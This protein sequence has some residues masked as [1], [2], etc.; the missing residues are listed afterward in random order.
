MVSGDCCV[1]L[2]CDTIGLSAV[3]GCG[4]C[5]SYSLTTHIFAS[6]RLVTGGTVLCPCARHFF[7]ASF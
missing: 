1:A 2:P 7:L 6:L 4:I 3:C 5:L